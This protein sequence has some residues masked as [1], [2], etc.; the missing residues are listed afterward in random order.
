MWGEAID[1]HERGVITA[2]P[3]ITHRLPLSEFIKGVEIMRNRTDD[4]IK[5]VL[6]P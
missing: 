2:E 5:V 3:L 6:E 4:A 1:L